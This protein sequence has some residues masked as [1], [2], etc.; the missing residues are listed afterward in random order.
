MELRAHPELTPAWREIRAEL[1]RLVGDST[2][3]MWLAPLKV[4][5]WDGK[6]LSLEAPRDTSTWVPKR[7][8]QALQR[9]VCTVL[10]PEVRAEVSG[11]HVHGAGTRRLHADSLELSQAFNPRHTF[12]QFVIGEGNRM[13]HAASL[14]IAE[15]PGQAHNP[16][17]LHAAPGLGKTHLLHAIAQLR[18]GLRQR[19]SRSAT[20]RPRR[21]PTIS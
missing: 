8:G 21:S 6:V 2:Y 15:N 7:F 18:P 9:S 19:R 20:P 5:A 3:E 10:G 14:A 11:P 1:R 4:T 16:L 13:A 17:F 12:N